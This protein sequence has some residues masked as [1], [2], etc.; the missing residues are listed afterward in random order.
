L[1]AAAAL[2]SGCGEADPQSKAQFIEKADQI[3]DSMVVEQRRALHD[4]GRSYSASAEDLRDALD[5][6]RDVIAVR[7]ERIQDLGEPKEPPRIYIA[8]LRRYAHQLEDAA[9]GEDGTA[10]NPAPVQAI[11]EQERPMVLREEKAYGLDR[12][13][14]LDSKPLPVAGQPQPEAQE[15]DSTR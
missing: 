15:S 9:V 7:L 8:S 11:L 4:L 6:Y 2:F 14:A 13:L 12:C 10:A 5:A 3:C 1:L